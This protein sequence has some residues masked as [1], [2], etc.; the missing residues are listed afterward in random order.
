MGLFVNSTEAFADAIGLS[1]FTGDETLKALILD[2]L[3]SVMML[4]DFVAAELDEGMKGI[5][6]TMDVAEML[7][8]TAVSI[9]PPNTV[10]Y[11]LALPWMVVPLVFFILVV[12]AWRLRPNLNLLQRISRYVLPLLCLQTM[13]STILAIIMVTY[14]IANAGK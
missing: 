5:N 1:P 4:D 13:A 12:M 11:V 3:F 2:A 9:N 8:A 10:A 6:A 14:A 7:N